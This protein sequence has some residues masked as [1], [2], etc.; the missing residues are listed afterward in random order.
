M[1]A[2]MFLNGD[3]GQLGIIPSSNK[4][5]GN[6]RS[7]WRIPMGRLYLVKCPGEIYI[8]QSERR[9]VRKVVIFKVITNIITL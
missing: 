3:I 2:Q 8:K 6:F 9:L 4:L 1:A 7:T 5:S